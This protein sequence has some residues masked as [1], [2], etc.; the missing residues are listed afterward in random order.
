M[1]N[2]YYNGL[3]QR[4]K[5]AHVAHPQDG[6]PVA[7][8]FSFEVRDVPGSPVHLLLEGAADFEIALNGVPVPNQATGW[9]L[10]RSFHKVALPTLQPGTNTITLSC[11]YENRMEVED[12]YLIGDFGV[13]VN[14]TIVR[15][16]ETLHFGDW[17][18]QGYLHYPGSMVYL[19]T[20]IYEP[21]PDQR[22]LLML[23]DH[24]AISVAIHLNGQVAGH[25]PWRAANGFDLT[26]HLRSG[27][28][29]IGIEVVGSPRNMLGPLH[30][31]RGYDPGTSWQSFRLEGIEDTPEYVLQPL[32][33]M[34]Q[35]R[36]VRV[37]R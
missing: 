16:P 24:S 23:G 37:A 19:D 9:Y 2:V 22:L 20:F 7:F 30:R 10:D 21:V 8:A 12:C 18:L 33:L 31:R 32:G 4:Y 27:E 14:R 36:I 34:E 35:V 15:E 17:C 25:I 3:P 6:T 28:N 11:A 13:D 1:R 26:P 29:E 5:W